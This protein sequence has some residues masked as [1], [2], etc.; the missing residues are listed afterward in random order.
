MLWL[1]ITR[2][3]VMGGLLGILVSKIVMDRPFY[4]ER[5]LPRFWLPIVKKINPRIILKIVLVALIF[6]SVSLVA[7]YLIGSVMN[8]LGWKLYSESEYLLS[9]LEIASPVLFLATIVILPVFEEWIFRSILLEEISSRTRSRM[10]GILASALAFGIFHLSNPGAYPA[11]AI[12]L[13]IGGMLLGIC[14][15]VSGLAG[16]ILSHILYNFLIFLV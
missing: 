3:I 16:S 2:I 15:L 8:E 11:L 1:D 5:I 6:S 12:P 14:Y 9:K 4:L 7:V 13:T 10:F